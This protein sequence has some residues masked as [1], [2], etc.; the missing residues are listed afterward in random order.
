MTENQTIL[1]AGATGSIGYA[2][3][4]VLAKRG[5]E[6]RCSVARPR[7]YVPEQTRFVTR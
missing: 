7:S 4:L 5:A 2:T 1:I 3:A 6:S